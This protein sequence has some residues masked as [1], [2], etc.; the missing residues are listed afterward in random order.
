VHGE[1]KTVFFHSSL[2]IFALFFAYIV[3]VRT[4]AGI[5]DGRDHGLAIFVP[6]VS[7]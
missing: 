2:Y 1:W 6:K 4:C 5:V 7:S 3:V